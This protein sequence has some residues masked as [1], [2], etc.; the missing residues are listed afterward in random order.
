MCPCLLIGCI[1]AA[2]GVSAWVAMPLLVAGLSISS[3]PKYTA[4]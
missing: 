4:L 1:A 2:A 3:L